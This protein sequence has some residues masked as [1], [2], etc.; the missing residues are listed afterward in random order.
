MFDT[1]GF[2]YWSDDLGATWSAGPAF[3]QRADGSPARGWNEGTLAELGDGT[4]LANARQYRGGRT[5]PH[6]RLLVAG[7][8]G[9]SDLV[10][11]DGGAV[12][13]LYEAGPPGTVRFLRVPVEELPLAS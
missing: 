3:T 9:Y 13:V 4:L 7:R 2:L 11:L 8:V 5:W 6:S 12:G 1:L 10:A